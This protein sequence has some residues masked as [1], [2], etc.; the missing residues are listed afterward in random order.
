MTQMSVRIRFRANHG[1]RW[2]EI[3]VSSEALEKL[4]RAWG[5]PR[6]LYTYV[7]LL[8]L[9]EPYWW[10]E[11]KV[12]FVG[13]EVVQNQPIDHRCEPKAVRQCGCK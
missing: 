3:E 2:D 5:S 4:G 6:A 11:N 7:A 1:R 13:W 12:G 10:S 9:P 8:V